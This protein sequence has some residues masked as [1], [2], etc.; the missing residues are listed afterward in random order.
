MTTEPTNPFETALAAA[1]GDR[2]AADAAASNQHMDDQLRAFEAR[3]AAGDYAAA[4]H[5]IETTRQKLQAIRVAAGLAPTPAV[6]TVA[7]LA[8]EH[9]A[10]S[11]PLDDT[12]HPNMV[13][14]LNTAR[15]GLEGD[16]LALAEATQA[17]KA[18]LG[19]QA[20]A[21]LL[22]D[23]GTYKTLS[24]AEKAHLPTLRAFASIGRRNQVKRGH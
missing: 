9:R 13:E 3:V 4:P 20:Y 12:L 8:A 22:A 15:A 5:L 17:L 10:A 19:P 23:A 1:T 11:F 24:D 6:K 18:E 21:K 2:T 7:E 14:L 16:K